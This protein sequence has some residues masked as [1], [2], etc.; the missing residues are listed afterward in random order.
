MPAPSPSDLVWHPERDM[1]DTVEEAQDKRQKQSFTTG[2]PGGHHL[3]PFDH[4]L[5]S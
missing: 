4:Q 2:N 1:V 5:W 3:L